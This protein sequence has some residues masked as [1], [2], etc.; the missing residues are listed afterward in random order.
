MNFNDTLSGML[1][2]FIFQSREGWIGL[3]WESVDAHS[4]Y[5]VPVKNYNPFY[6]VVFMLLVVLL[7]LLFVNMFVGIVIET[8]NNQKARISFNHLLKNEQRSWLRLQIIT[9]QVKPMK[10]IDP[11]MKNIL[12]RVCIKVTQH[13]YFARFIMICIC[14]N[15]IVLAFKW[16]D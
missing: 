5:H 12:R 11:N 2:L 3:M 1:A 8:Y 4:I 6:I 13:R 14:L 7:C 10:L 15:T 16:F 9:Y